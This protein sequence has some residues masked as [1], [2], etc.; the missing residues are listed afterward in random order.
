[1]F[2]RRRPLAEQQWLGPSDDDFVDDAHEILGG[3]ALE[4]PQASSSPTRA[5][6]SSSRASLRLRS[7]SMSLTLSSPQEMRLALPLHTGINAASL[8]PPLWQAL[9]SSWPK[10]LPKMRV[11]SPRRAGRPR[12][13]A[14]NVQ[15][16]PT[17]RGRSACV[18]ASCTRLSK[19]SLSYARSP[20]AAP[21]VT[22]SVYVFDTRYAMSSKR[23]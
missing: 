5:M 7:P 1:M 22:S 6:G 3:S 23:A 16:R 17:A 15:T 21:D 4:L 9:S 2:H 19:L 18:P 11:I 12:A 10:A 13:R 14:G 20:S 8:Y